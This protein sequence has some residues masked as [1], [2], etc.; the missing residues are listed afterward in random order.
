MKP[1]FFLSDELL[2][3]WFLM[4]TYFRFLLVTVDEVLISEQ[5]NLILVM[6]IGIEEGKA[7]KKERRQSKPCFM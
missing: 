6:S 7:L 3:C 2:F 1:E 4:R 5:L